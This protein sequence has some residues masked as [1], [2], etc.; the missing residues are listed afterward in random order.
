LFYNGLKRRPDTEFESFT[1]VE[2]LQVKIKDDI[3]NNIYF[4]FPISTTEGRPALVNSFSL[5]AFVTV[6]EKLIIV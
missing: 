4:G 1:V 2:D 3:H 6:V 5:I